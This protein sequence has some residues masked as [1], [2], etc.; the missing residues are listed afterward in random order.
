MLLETR[1]QSLQ[2]DIIVTTLHQRGLEFDCELV[3]LFQ[4]PILYD[5]LKVYRVNT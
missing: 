1:I 4:D 3:A 5:H 2:D